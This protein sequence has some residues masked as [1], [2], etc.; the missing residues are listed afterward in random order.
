MAA[1]QRQGGLLTGDDLAAY[2]PV[3]QEPVSTTYR[4]YTVLC[5]PP[6]CSGFQYLQTLNML[7]GFNLASLG[8]N[9][10]ETIHVMAEAMKLAVADRI[11]YAARPDIPIA[12]LLSKDYAAQRRA[13]IDPQRAAPSE[14]ERY[15]GPPRPGVIVA[16]KPELAVKECTTHFDVV[17]SE[18]NMISITQSLGDGFGSGVMADDTGIV[19]NDFAYWFDADPRSPNV[20]GPGKKAEMCLAPALVLR[21]DAPFHGDRHARIVRHHG[22]DAAND[23]QCPRFRV[24]H[25][26]G[27]R[28]TPLPD[29]SRH[30]D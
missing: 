26:G 1:V 5:P 30:H 22:D 4:G 13:L 11:A 23:R 3:W 29:L 12:G 17:D 27:D 8:Q 6:P 2:E 25:P 14:G 7:E 16:G 10:A 18:G 9:T 15:A 28:G 19:L 24:Q 20:I 21:D